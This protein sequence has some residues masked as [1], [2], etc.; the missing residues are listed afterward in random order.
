M[1]GFK[2]QLQ[3]LFNP[4]HIYCRLRTLGIDHSAARVVTACYEKAIYR[5]ILA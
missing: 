2:S 5:F 3:H 4:L 1:S